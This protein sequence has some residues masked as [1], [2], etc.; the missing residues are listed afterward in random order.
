MGRPIRNLSFNATGNVLSGTALA[1]SVIE[2][3]SEDLTKRKH[4]D[5][6]RGT[7]TVPAS[8]QFS[9]ALSPLPIG[10]HQLRVVQRGGDTL[11]EPLTAVATSAT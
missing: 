7:I 10:T 11:S 8:G 1:G 4:R 6:L 3:Y 9:Q 2:V 5:V